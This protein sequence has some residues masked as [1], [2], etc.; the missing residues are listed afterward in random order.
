MP[1]SET[2]Y[3]DLANTVKK[4]KLMMMGIA[5]ASISYLYYMATMISW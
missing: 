2:D 4:V 5:Y 3:R 1:A